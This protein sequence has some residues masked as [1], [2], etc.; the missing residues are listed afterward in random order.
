MNRLTIIP[1]SAKM[2][3]AGDV[4]VQFGVAMLGICWGWRSRGHRAT[5]QDT[6]KPYDQGL[7]LV[8]QRRFELLTSPV[9][10][11]RNPLQGTY[12]QIRSVPS[13]TSIA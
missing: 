11:A 5:L 8:D 2:A 6:E 7:F 10:G 4:A 3:R 9:R 1:C 13:G 12:T